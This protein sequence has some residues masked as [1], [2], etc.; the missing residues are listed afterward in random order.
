M[1]VSVVIVETVDFVKVLFIED[2]PPNLDDVSPVLVGCLD[3]ELEVLDE[4]NELPEPEPVEI[5]V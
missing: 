3:A 2:G 4:V 1:L 5:L